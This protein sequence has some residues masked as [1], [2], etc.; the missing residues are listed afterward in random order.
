MIPFPSADRE[1][2]IVSLFLAAVERIAPPLDDA[3]DSAIDHAHAL[4]Q[5]LETP[6]RIAFAGHRA[7]GTATIINRVL[8]EAVLPVPASGQRLPPT[9][10]SHA[11]QDRTVAGW[12][13]H[14]AV[15]FNGR[16]LTAAAAL[17]PDFIS[18]EIECPALA[19]MSLVDLPVFD[20]P[21]EA[22]RGAFALMRL[23]DRM[24]WCASAVAESDPGTGDC[25]AL[26]PARLARSCGLVL[27]DADALTGADLQRAADR[28]AGGPVEPFRTVVSLTRAATHGA[29]DRALHGKVDVQLNEMI[30]KTARDFSAATLVRVRQTVA[31][32]LTPAIARLRQDH[33]DV[34]S[35][36]A[37]DL[38]LAPGFDALPAPEAKA[39]LSDAGHCAML[40][41]TRM[42]RMLAKV[43]SG[44]IADPDGFIL[45]AQA[46][47]DEV[48]TEIETAPDPSDPFLRELDRA[49]DL[50]ILLQ[51]ETTPTAAR[52]CAHILRQ[53]AEWDST[54][55]I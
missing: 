54:A 24:F 34:M 13:D 41:R 3:L 9:V 1:L 46:L 27:T 33:P 28:L 47:V 18:L 30:I 48:R 53:L 10:I 40:V 8:G 4:R 32:H 12:W 39:A 21:E 55:G 22:K 52:D 16:D 19:E 49:A 44:A 25:L 35:A 31:R 23:A 43:Q 36:L 14:R 11:T 37:A 15:S 5:R 7:A 29:Q 50:L 6:P 42:S 26:I 38:G 45:A 17:S 2:A 20:N 51:Y